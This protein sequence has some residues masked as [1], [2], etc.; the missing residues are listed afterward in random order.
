MNHVSNFAPTSI[1]V[2]IVSTCLGTPA[3]EANSTNVPLGMFC[4]QQN[5]AN[6][7]S[8]IT[9]CHVIDELE[10]NTVHVLFDCGTEDKKKETK[11][12]QQVGSSLTYTG[13]ISFSCHLFCKYFGEIVQ[14]FAL[15]FQLLMAWSLSN[16]L[17]KLS[18]ADSCQMMK[19]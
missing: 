19:R 7:I 6:L 16:A 1:S 13:M 18:L 5:L 8:K 2:T 10:P 12:M 9:F 3:L 17:A 15:R 4:T 14:T 11:K